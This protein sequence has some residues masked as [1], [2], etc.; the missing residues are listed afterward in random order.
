MSLFAAIAGMLAT[1]AV[2]LL[3]VSVLVS[4]G[5]AR[6]VRHGKSSA[7]TESAAA[8]L[9]VGLM[10]REF[11]SLLFTLW[12]RPSGWLPPRITPGDS[13]KPPVLLLHGLFQNRSCLLRLQWH[14]HRA[15]YRA[16]SI[17]TPPWQTLE[18][19]TSR[20]GKGI[21]Q[22]RTATGAD[23]IYLVGHSMGGILARS[24]LQRHGAE[25]IAGCITLGAPHTGSELAVFA[26]SMLGRALLPGSP[27][28]E[29][30]NAAPRPVGISLTAIYSTDDNIIVPSAN[31]RL[32]GATNI[33]LS[34]MGHTAMLFSQQVAE[35]VLDAL[36]NV[37]SEEP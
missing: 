2:I 21:E 1:I 28:L 31:A 22:L 19:L 20:V 14:L 4:F 30:L 7:S 35:T 12:L 13:A 10:L 24:Y 16:M 34:G 36:E 29:G 6:Q 5:I 17:N 11:A 18:E 15:G 37:R 25:G 3:A 26:V 33:E 23:Q 8:M 9:P 32:E 27:M